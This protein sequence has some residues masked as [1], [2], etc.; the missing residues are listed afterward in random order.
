MKFNKFN[1]FTKTNKNNVSRRTPFYNFLFF[2]GMLIGLAN[3]A[4]ALPPE[5]TKLDTNREVIQTYARVYFESKEF[6]R[7][8]AMV[9]RYLVQ[10]SADGNLWLTLGQSQMKT[11]KL[12]Q[13]CQAFQ[14]ALA[15]LK[16]PENNHFARYQLADC[17]NQGK[18][19]DEAKKVL[20]HLVSEGVSFT[21]S[22]ELALRL[23]RENKIHSGDPLP[24][25]AKRNPPR[26]HI[27]GAFG[28]GFDSNV[29]LIEEDV[30][31]N[32]P[33][34]GRGSFFVTPG[35]QVGYQGYAFGK[36]FESQYVL[37]FTDYLNKVASTFNSLYQRADFSL[38][39][40]KAEGQ[41]RY[42]FFGD[43]FYLNRG[44]FQLYD[45]E[46]GTSFS[47]NFIARDDFNLS[48]E[49]PIKFQKYAQD[50]TAN[51]ANDRT[52]EDVQ[53]KT[54][55]HFSKGGAE[56]ISL[57]GIIDAQWTQGKNYRLLGLE[58][59]LLYLTEL[60][61]F[62]SFGLLN[63][64][65]LDASLQVYTSSDTKRRDLLL[66]AGTGV[67]KSLSKNLNLGL[68]I[69]YQKN[70]SSVMTARYNKMVISLQLSHD[71]K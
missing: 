67:L 23:L 39:D 3:L 10:D 33:V 21:N 61:W 9:S 13:A 15:L 45:W 32:T 65:N 71:F 25:Y 62:S 56:L 51:P 44:P 60:P 68:D 27:T 28:S 37:S 43:L 6:D 57:Q 26:W 20:E 29:L 1:K 38:S 59:P 69:G 19:T 2:S 24:T 58:I 64:F 5:K 50:P 41:T 35:L 22:P 48:Y 63:T 54:S 47:K 40:G 7:E 36:V 55:A 8:E 17:L 4:F 66:K 18:L 16:D 53:W 34:S 46:L 42:G 70:I 52:G 14:K 31:N 11:R 30:I 49:I 12:A